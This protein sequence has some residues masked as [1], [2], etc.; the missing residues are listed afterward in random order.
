MYWAPTASWVIGGT[1]CF[2][3]MM[4]AYR[5]KLLPL[6]MQESLKSEEDLKFGDLNSEDKKDDA[7]RYEGLKNSESANGKEKL[8]DYSDLKE[9]GDDKD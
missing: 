4:I 5:K 6:A 2:I 7:F 9:D 3:C 1:Y 8:W